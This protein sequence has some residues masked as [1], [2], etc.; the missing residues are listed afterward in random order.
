M[1]VTQLD[2]G[3]PLHIKA[4]TAIKPVNFNPF[5][6]PVAAEEPEDPGTVNFVLMTRKGNKQ[7]FKEFEVP[8][9]SE[10]A[11]NLKNREEVCILP[12]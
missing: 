9:N 1:K 7:Q 12:W 10:L 5:L 3:V 11:A 6:Q 4:R 2:I 8:V